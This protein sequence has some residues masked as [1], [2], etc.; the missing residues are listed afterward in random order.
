MTSKEKEIVNVLENQVKPMLA[1][2]L[3]SLDYVGFKDGVVSVRLQGTCKGCPL[4]QLTL[5]AGIEELLK[6]KVE[7]VKSVAS[8]E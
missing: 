2:H 5:K 3:G 7:G 1:V 8:V 4:S 6:S